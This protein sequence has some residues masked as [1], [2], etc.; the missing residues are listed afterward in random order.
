M[1]T[2]S[3]KSLCVLVGFLVPCFGVTSRTEAGVIPWLYDSIFGYGWGGSGYGG[4][5]GG[6]YGGGM[7]YSAGYGGWGYGGS[8][9]GASYAPGY[10]YGYSGYSSP[11]YAMPTSGAGCCGTASYATPSQGTGCCGTPTY[12]MPLS[13]TPANSNPVTP[14][15]DA[16]PA[17]GLYKSEYG[18][19]LG[20]YDSGYGYS[21]SSGYTPIYSGDSGNCCN[22]CATSVGTPVESG[23]SGPT[24]T[25]AGSSIPGSK[26][27]KGLPDDD[28]KPRSGAGARDTG[29]GDALPPDQKRPMRELNG[30]GEPT[31][32]QEPNIDEENPTPG[33]ILFVPTE[34]R[35]AVRYVPSPTRT[36]IAV[37]T[38]TARVVRIGRPVRE[39]MAR[40]APKSQLA[41]NP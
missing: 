4:G 18:P 11:S 36:R 33:K 25:P 28:M 37:P 20:Y 39:L 13:P 38:S 21:Y 31:E 9:Y 6:G 23:T 8:G 35:I 7:P 16:P 27:T 5:M 41:S 15:T 3:A 10:S 12:S 32:L 26:K 22:P 29:Q 34:A 2:I 30:V 40:S 19:S 14:S 17:G 24:P 1:R